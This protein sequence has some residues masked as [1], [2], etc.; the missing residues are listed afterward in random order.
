MKLKIVFI[1]LA[2][3]L[4]AVFVHADDGLTS[5]F[6]YY[7][8]GSVQVDIAPENRDAL[9]GTNVIFKGNV[10]NTNSYPIVDGAVYI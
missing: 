6:D 3:L 9:S 5:C 2:F 4:P 8:F 10:R 7:K 1:A